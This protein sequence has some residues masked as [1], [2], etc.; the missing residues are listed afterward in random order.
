MTRQKI[1]IIVLI[2]LIA[3]VGADYYYLS[4]KVATKQAGDLE[5]MDQNN[6][7]NSTT[8]NSI[9]NKNTVA[10]TKKQPTSECSP[11]SANFSCEPVTQ[12]MEMLEPNYYPPKVCGCKPTCPS[13]QA[14]IVSQGSGYWSDGSHKGT[15]TCSSEYPPS[16]ENTN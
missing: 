3:L 10:P 2:I 13:G 7:T 12:G 4:Q 11:S 6:Y 14:V 16:S 8:T 15:F 1:F 9:Q 5:N